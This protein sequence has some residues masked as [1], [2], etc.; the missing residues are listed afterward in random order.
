MRFSLTSSAKQK[1]KMNCDNLPQVAMPFMNTVHCEELTI[2]NRLDELLSAD[3][4]SEPEISACLDEWVTHTEA[5]FA[6]ENRL[7]EEYRF[8]A[9]LIHMGEH[10]HAY[11]Y[12]LDLQK[13]WNE[14]HNTETLK[15]YVKE[16][17]PAWFEQHLNTMD[18]VTAQFLSQF[19]IEVEI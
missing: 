13:S 18:A 14:H 7:M 5:H 8:P 17:W 15:T 10:E 4:I 3:E 12:L 6:R 9:Y 19:N 1:A 11:Q 16:T 2:V